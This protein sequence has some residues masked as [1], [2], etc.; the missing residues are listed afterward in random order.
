MM[1]VRRGQ[2]RRRSRWTR[3]WRSWSNYAHALP[4]WK[5]LPTSP[6]R[7]AEFDERDTQIIFWDK[8]VSK[9]IGYF[10][11]IIAN[12]GCS[13]LSIFKILTAISFLRGMEKWAG[14]WLAFGGRLDFDNHFGVVDLEYFLWNFKKEIGNLRGGAYICNTAHDLD[15]QQAVMNSSQPITGT[16]FCGT[17]QVSSPSSRFRLCSTLS[18][19]GASPPARTRPRRCRRP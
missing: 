13:D 2:R 4:S 1:Q 9:A 6:T 12:N 11:M 5:S 17:L 8:Q 19:R 10:L 18:E 14:V 3:T 16:T 15:A 7:L